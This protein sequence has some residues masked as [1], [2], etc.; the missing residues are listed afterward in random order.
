ML[1]ADREVHGDAALRELLLQLPERAEEV[2]ALA[3]EHV[4]E[5]EARDPELL[6]ALPDPRR[7]H[8]DAHH[9]AEDDE[10]ALDHPQ[11]AARL[12]LE[13]RVAGDVDQVDLPLLPLGVGERERDRH[14]A[15]LLVVVPVRDRRARV[16]RAEPV[17]L[18]GLEEQ[19]LDERGLAR[20]AV[21]DD[22]D[23]ADLSGLES[24]HA[25]SSSSAGVV[26]RRIV[27][28]GRPRD[29]DADGRADGAAE[30]GLEAEDRLRVQL[31]DARLGHAE[32]LADLAQRQLLVVV[33]RDDELLALG[34]AR[35]RLAERLLQLG[36]R[37]RGL[38]LRAPACPRSCRSA[39]PGRRR[40]RPSRARRARRSTSARSRSGCRRA[41]PRSCRACSRSPRRSGR[42][43]ASSRARRS[44]A[45][46]PGRARARSAAPSRAR[47][48]RR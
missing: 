7:S 6:G 10:R 46:C 21:S 38:R 31:R 30:A 22:G 2:G 33:E 23:V 35:D 25:N 32:H 11:R 28:R 18:A 12:A 42:G 37:E 3:V 8:L 44:P 15:L 48:A 47:A 20:A 45:R 4:D 14:P 39:R 43:G 5:E 29:V 27:T 36:L 34:Q 9:A 40:P 16:D 19:R 17:R 26:G 24:G 41:R 13:A 1:G